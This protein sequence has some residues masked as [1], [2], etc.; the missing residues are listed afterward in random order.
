MDTKEPWKTIYDVIGNE[1]FEKLD[2]KF[3]RELKLK[4]RR[5][6]NGPH[7]IPLEV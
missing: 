5:K 3:P 6:F 1:Y 2:V 7:F 4:C